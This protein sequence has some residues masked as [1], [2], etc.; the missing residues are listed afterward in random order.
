M[1]SAFYNIYIHFFLV[2]DEALLVFPY[3]QL[4]MWHGRCADSGGGAS[5]SATASQ[6]AF[7]VQHCA[8]TASIT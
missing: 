3:A 6:T 2:P 8:I 1:H 4:S 5:G 7:L